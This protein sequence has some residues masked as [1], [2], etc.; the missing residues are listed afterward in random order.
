MSPTEGSRSAS[1]RAQA[2]TSEPTCEAQRGYIPAVTLRAP[3]SLASLLAPPGVAVHVLPPLETVEAWTRARLARHGCERPPPGADDDVDVRHALYWILRMA[4]RTYRR[5]L[6]PAAPVEPELVERFLALL[7]CRPDR[8]DEH[9][10]LHVDARSSLRRA[11]HVAT[12]VRAHPGPVL[13]VG[14]DDAVTL[15][16]ALL[17]VPDLHAVDIDE[18]ILRFLSESAARV[19]ATIH[20]AR[21]DVL[22]EPLPPSLRRRCAAVLADP[23]RSY[24][25]TLSFLLFGAAA[26]RR[27]AP[28]R[29]Y[30]ADD[31][32]WTFEHDQ[33]VEALGG[34]GLRVVETHEDVHA[35]PLDPALF[36]LERIARETGADAAWLRALVESTC[37]WSGLYV[38]ERAWFPRPELRSGF[39]AE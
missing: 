1:F 19:D 28:A 17:G 31:P 8:E 4:E 30:W 13:A 14:D 27:D 11:M 39:S 34:A 25:P 16:L 5:A 38:L 35:Y 32:D 9:A 37:G 15:A 33:V 24:E 6:A 7:G 23:I 20:T 22:E 3:A 18:R 10:Q 36:D 26:L 29:L 21:V 2:R 12:H